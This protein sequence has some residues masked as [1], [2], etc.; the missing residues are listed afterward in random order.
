MISRIAFISLIFLF[1]VSSQSLFAQNKKMVITSDLQFSYAHK[2]FIEND[3][4]TAII[5]YKRFLHFFP[6]S[7]QINQVKFNIGVSLFNLKQYHKAAKIFNSIIISNVDDAFTSEAYFY[8][9]NAFKFIGNTGYAQIVLQNYLKLTEDID[10]R[11]R[12]YLNLCKILLAE[13]REGKSESLV[14]AK[15]NLFMISESGMKKLNINHFNRAICPDL[16]GY[17]TALSQLEIISL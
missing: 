6:E 3:F 2:L 11:D 9:S 16:A 1:S 4:E 7:N 10:I 14:Y 15:R 13:A 5:E 8:Q 12:I 17:K